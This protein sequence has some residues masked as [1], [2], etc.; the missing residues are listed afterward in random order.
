MPWMY[1]VKPD[2]QF[3][4]SCGD[5]GSMSSAERLGLDGK[6]ET[7]T[8]TKP[9]VGYSMIVGSITARSFQHQDYWITTPVTKIVK[10]WRDEESCLNVIFETLNSTYHWKS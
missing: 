2:G 1:K 4:Y 3:D 5:S 6:V 7:I 9:L 10:Q 8:N